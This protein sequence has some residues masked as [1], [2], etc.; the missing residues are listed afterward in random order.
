MTLALVAAPVSAQTA[1][2]AWI[3][4]WM[5]RDVAAQDVRERGESLPFGELARLEGENVRLFLHDG[6]VRGGVVESADPGRVTLRARA[7]S[8]WYSYTVERAQVQR[9]ERRPRR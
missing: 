6:R 7:T 1:D 5:V 4:A 3:D 9:I 8:G 2:E